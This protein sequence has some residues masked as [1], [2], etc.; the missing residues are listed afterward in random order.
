MATKLLSEDFL[1]KL[2]YLQILVGKLLA[3]KRKAEHFSLQKGGSVE[4]SEHRAYVPGDDLRYLDWNVFARHGEPFIKEFAAE[5]DFHL[6]ILVDASRSMNFGEPDRFR[7]AKE[8]ALAVTYIALSQYDTCSVFCLKDESISCGKNLRGTDAIYPLA[9]QLGEVESEGQC[10][11]DSTGDIPVLRK[12]TKNLCIFFL[13]DFYDVDSVKTFYRKLA[14]RGIR[15]HSV[16]V[17]TPE[18]LQPDLSGVNQLVDME[19][20]DTLDISVS[21]EDLK[22]YRQNLKAHV[23]RI[24]SISRRYGSGYIRLVSDMSLVPTVIRIF[25]RHDILQ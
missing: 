24:Q 6:L 12:G 17:L 4:F 2:E 23:Q 9:R 15:H 19:T 3:G 14:G 21:G 1:K 25:S 7:Y 16:H 5:R 8:F 18:E 20:G 10:D 11:L 22:R 13:S